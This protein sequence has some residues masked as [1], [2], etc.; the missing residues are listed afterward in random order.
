M[1][2]SL[3]GRKVKQIRKNETTSLREIETT[4]TVKMGE[5]TSAIQSRIIP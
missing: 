2:W 5:R 3:R 4:F 1:L